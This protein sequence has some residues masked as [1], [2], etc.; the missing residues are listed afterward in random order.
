MW[1]PKGS[2][3]I[4]ANGSQAADKEPQHLSYPDN[5]PQWQSLPPQNCSRPQAASTLKT[6]LMKSRS[7]RQPAPQ[8][9]LTLD[10][11]KAPGHVR[12]MVA[13]AESGFYDNG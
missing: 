10:P 11:E 3:L 7:K 9:Q 12:N 6:S 8:I 13:L 2:A 4:L 1:W 5:E